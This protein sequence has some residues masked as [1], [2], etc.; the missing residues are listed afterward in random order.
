MTSTEQS[1]PA[2]TPTP[3]SILF[4]AVSVALIVFAIIILILLGNYWLP[5]LQNEIG[6]DISYRMVLNTTPGSDFVYGRD[7]IITHGPLGFV[8]MAEPHPIATPLR[9]IINSIVT[10]LTVVL[11]VHAFTPRGAFAQPRYWLAIALYLAVAI[12]IGLSWP[13]IIYSS[14][15]LLL[16]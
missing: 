6:V 16:L 10:V 2:P 15:V 3:L 9:L 13:L 11:F 14:V 8:A 5:G 12:M 7:L 1:E 4:A